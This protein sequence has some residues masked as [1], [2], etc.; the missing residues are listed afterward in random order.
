[1]YAIQPKT[2]GRLDPH[3]CDYATNMTDAYA[4]ARE[5]KEDCTIWKEG[6][7]A[8]MKWMYVTDEQVS[9]AG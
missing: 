6:T 1:M 3:G 5:W 9:S 2:W 7:E 4:Y 8:W